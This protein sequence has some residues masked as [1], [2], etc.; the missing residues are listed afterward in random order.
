VTDVKQL[1][2]TLKSIATEL[3]AQYLLGYTPTR[4]LTGK[5]EWRGL[6]VV[7][8]RPDVTVRARPG[9]WTR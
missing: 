8:R 3:R 9:Y 5:P 6:R 7:V 2:A 1:P 4:P